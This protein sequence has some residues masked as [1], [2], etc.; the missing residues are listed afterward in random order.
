M[1]LRTG[2]FRG[3]LGL[4]LVAP[5][6]AVTALICLLMVV[7]ASSQVEKSLTISATSKGEAVALSLADD[8]EKG[9][10]EG[11]TTLL[12]SA[13]DSSKLIAGVGYIYVRTATAESSRT[14]SRP[15]FPRA[16]S[17]P[18]CSTRAASPLPGASR[19]SARSTFPGKAAA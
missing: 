3:G 10:L 6:A 12:Q 15:R 7:V 4:K 2:K 8:A 19:S 5:S 1:T 14:L 16:S 9:V 11:S 17:A 13:I 18:T